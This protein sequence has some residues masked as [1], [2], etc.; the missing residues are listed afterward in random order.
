MGPA[1]LEH[2]ASLVI[3]KR[4]QDWLLGR[5]TAKQALFMASVLEQPGI[6]HPGQLEVLPTATGSP[7]V[8]ISGVPVPLSLSLSHRAGSAF[9]CLRSGGPVGCDLELVEPRSAAFVEDYFTTAERALIAEA[10][11]EGATVT[12]N[13]LWSAKESVLKLLEVGLT[14][15]ARRLEV[16]GAPGAPASNWQQFAVLQTE[17]SRTFP[18]WW[19]R[20]GDWIL[21]VATDEQT[22]PPI[23]L[24]RLEGEG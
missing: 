23:H 8:W 11:S 17:T 6:D 13:G 21:T 24:S 3:D 4:R 22:G 12:A 20:R 9:C 2:L 7:A 19:C 16:Q 18:G 1:E 15:D 10:R 5:W 14:I